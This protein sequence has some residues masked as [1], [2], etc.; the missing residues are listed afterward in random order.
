[1][2]FE[3]L[4]G[5]AWLAA[6]MALGAVLM[7]WLAPRF[8]G[9]QAEQ[10]RQALAE[11][12]LRRDAERLRELNVELHARMDEQTQRHIEQQLLAQKTHALA[13]ATAEEELRRTQDQLKRLIALTEEG[14]T[15]SPTAF[16][17]TQFDED[18]P[19]R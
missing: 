8:S 2:S 16:Q 13:L 19:S 17:P 3:L 7:A 11:A 15:I 9:A 12:Q 18:E 5:L 10:A 6:G 14:D 4:M 1:M